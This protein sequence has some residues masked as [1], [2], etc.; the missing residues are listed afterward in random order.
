MTADLAPL[1]LF[2]TS[3]TNLHQERT[4]K[5][6]PCIYNAP[7]FG[8]ECQPKVW[9]VV[10]GNCHH[11][12][13]PRCGLG[14]AKHEYMRM[15]LGCV[16]LAKTMTLYFLTITCKGKEET[17]QYAEEKYGERT[18]RL[19][20]RCRAQ[21]KRKDRNWHYVQVTERQKRLHPH[22]HFITT[23][24]PEDAVSSLS[25]KWK[26]AEDGRRIYRVVQSY[27]S[28][29][30]YTSLTACDLGVQY[31]ITRVSDA[32]AASRYVAKYL[33]KPTIFNAD[34]PKGWKRIRYSQSFPKAPEMETNAIALV[35]HEDWYRLA[36][37][38]VIV[39][40]DTIDD[41]EQAHN[42]LWYHDTIIRLK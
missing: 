23:F 21:S 27:K 18:N 35:K 3:P 34:W 15:V 17:W 33:F 32:E 4:S 9:R 16:E 2:S 13:C 36:K 1:D 39:L 22:S 40:V 10:Q 5:L 31:N 11:W 6:F 25:R 29:W 38:A 14:R 20:D 28:E 26:T 24:L 12:D 42:H 41:Y 19:L 7:Y 30:F 8:Y 37:N